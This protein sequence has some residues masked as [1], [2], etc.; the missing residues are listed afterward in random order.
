M[1]NKLRHR[2]EQLSITT[3]V[4][5]SRETT[6]K[7]SWSITNTIKQNQVFLQE[8]AMLTTRDY[9]I[10]YVCSSELHYVHSLVTDVTYCLM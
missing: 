9:E 8:Y 2:T 3:I 6:L 4:S 1:Q 10:I 5:L 7:K